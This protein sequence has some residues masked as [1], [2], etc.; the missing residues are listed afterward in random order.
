[1]FLALVFL[2]VTKN[3]AFLQSEIPVLCFEKI[4]TDDGSVSSF[5]PSMIH[6]FLRVEEHLNLR[7]VNGRGRLGGM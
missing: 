7:G 3:S 5:T 1:M 4:E 6:L 2:T